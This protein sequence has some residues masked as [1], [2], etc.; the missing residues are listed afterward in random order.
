M[1]VGGGM[2]LKISKNSGRVIY[3]QPL[4][5]LAV[6]NIKERTVQSDKVNLV[7]NYESNQISSLSQFYKY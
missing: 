4:I 1:D 7:N 6:D 2:G 5:Q 3:G